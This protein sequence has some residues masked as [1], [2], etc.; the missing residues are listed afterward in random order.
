MFTTIDGNFVISIPVQRDQPKTKQSVTELLLERL[1]TIDSKDIHQKIDVKHHS[2]DIYGDPRFLH[3]DGSSGKSS[4]GTNDFDTVGEK[5]DLLLKD[6]KAYITVR[7]TAERITP[8]DIEFN[9]WRKNQ[10]I[11]TRVIEVDLLATEQRRRLYYKVMEEQ[12][13]DPRASGRRDYRAVQNETILDG[14]QT[15]ELFSRILGAAEGEGDKEDITV[16]TR[17]TNTTRPFSSGM[18]LLY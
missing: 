6:G 11:V 16:K 2:E 12:T 5:V 9:V 10:A 13:H 14:H 15:L 8:V 7:V 17:L 4:Y 3:A 18:D 1:S